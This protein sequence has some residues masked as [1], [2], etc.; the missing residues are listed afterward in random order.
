MAEMY[1]CT[2]DQCKI[3]AFHYANGIAAKNR[4]HYYEKISLCRGRVPGWLDLCQH[5]AQ[6]KPPPGSSNVGDWLCFGIPLP[7]HHLIVVSSRL[8][9]ASTA[10]QYTLFSPNMLETD[11]L[12]NNV[13]YSEVFLKNVPVTCIPIDIDAEYTSENMKVIDALLKYLRFYIQLEMRQLT[14]GAL[15]DL[16]EWPMYVYK[17]N[18]KSKLSLHLYQ[19]LPRNVTFVNIEEVGRFLAN[20]KSRMTF[21]PKTRGKECWIDDSVCASNRSLRLPLCSKMESGVLCKKLE[22]YDTLGKQH[23]PLPLV[24]VA[25]VHYPHNVPTADI[26]TLNLCYPGK[27]RSHWGISCQPNER[28][29][30]R[31]KTFIEIN[32]GIRVTRENSRTKYSYFDTSESFCP[33]VAR[34]H[35]HSKQYFVW[36]WD[37]HKLT[38]HCWSF[39]CKETKSENF[40]TTK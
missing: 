12:G 26:P 19:H 13:D 16:N 35:R 20:V 4:G 3:T 6:K 23:C 29:T 31:I 30:S 21:N 36:N 14:R 15:I 22:H 34:R 25:L 37:T 1:D 17:S 28:I 40:V 24:T 38:R 5:Y 8:C 10:R 9:I 18:T 33:F 2:S 7:Q 39:K 27:V 11:V 32:L